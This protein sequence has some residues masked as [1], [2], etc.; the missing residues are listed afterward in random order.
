MWTIDKSCTSEILNALVYNFRICINLLTLISLYRMMNYLDWNLNL[1]NNRI[2][3]RVL[4]CSAR[5]GPVRLGYA[6]LCW[7]R[8][9]SARL[10]SARFDSV[11]LGSA[12]FGYS[13]LR[14]YAIP[15][16]CHLF[17]SQFSKN[18]NNL[19]QRLILWSRLNLFNNIIRQKLNFHHFVHLSLSVRSSPSLCP[20][21]LINPPI[22]LS[23]SIHPSPTVRSI[24]FSFTLFLSRSSLIYF[25][26]GSFMTVHVHWICFEM[27]TL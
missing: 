7:V 2:D 24:T 11:R 17:S 16:G 26:T 9:C 5:L 10:G 25:L 23:P 27:L 14:I 19:S 18:R 15:S 8:L 3:W 6:R 12:A 1:S 13:T 20:F 4:L 22:Y 21:I